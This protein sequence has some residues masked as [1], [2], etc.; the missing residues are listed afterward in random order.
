MAL[1]TKNIHLANSKYTYTIDNQSSC[2]G[3]ADIYEITAMKSDIVDDMFNWINEWNEWLINTKWLVAI[4]EYHESQNE[5][6]YFFRI[7]EFNSNYSNEDYINKWNSFWFGFIS[8]RV[9]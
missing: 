1:M 3:E 2:W 8:I 7:Y 9:V 4:S 6:Y 5:N